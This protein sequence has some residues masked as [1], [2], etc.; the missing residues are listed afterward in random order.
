MMGTVTY[1]SERVTRYVSD[2]FIPFRVDFDNESALLRKYNIFWTP[3]ILFTDQDG[4]ERHR[5]TGFLP[6]LV[7]L[8]HLAMGN[9]FVAF[10]GHYYSHAAELFDAVA[11]DF[12]GSMLAPEAVYFRSVARRKATNDDSHLDVAV[13]E[14]EHLYP[15]SEWAL[16][17]LPWKD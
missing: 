10:W 12:P 5:I 4:N 11:G 6:P 7:F 8:S 16:R 15:D 2:N 9:A 3:T 14:L 13:K 1:P 17:A